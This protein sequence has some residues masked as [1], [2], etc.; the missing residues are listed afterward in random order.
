LPCKRHKTNEAVRTSK[1]WRQEGQ[2]NAD[3]GGFISGIAGLAAL[4]ASFGAQRIFY[5]YSGLEK[6]QACTGELETAA[7]DAYNEN[8]PPKGRRWILA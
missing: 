8:P 5:Y 4:Q 1:T 7:A 6:S 3:A 2:Q